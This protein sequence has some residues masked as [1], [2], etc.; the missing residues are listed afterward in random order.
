M[1]VRR[2][3]KPAKSPAIRAPKKVPAERIETISDFC[4]EGRANPEGSEPFLAYAGL[5]GSLPV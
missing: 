4:Q 3:M 2:P 5:F 1:V